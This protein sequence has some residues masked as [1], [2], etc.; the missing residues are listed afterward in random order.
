MNKILL[1]SAAAMLAAFS[2]SAAITDYSK[3]SKLDLSSTEHFNRAKAPM[4]KVN[5]VINDPV[6][7]KG[8]SRFYSVKA[9]TQIPMGQG[10]GQTETDMAKKIIFGDDGFVYFSSMQYGLT[11]EFIK[12]RIEGNK[13][14]V[15]LPQPYV[16]QH[17]LDDNGNEVEVITYYLAP[18]DY[19]IEAERDPDTGQI[20]S[21]Y[22]FEEAEP[23]TLVFAYDAESGSIRQESEIAV[24]TVVEY[25]GE[26]LLFRFADAEY[27]MTWEKNV[28]VPEIPDNL[29]YESYF[30]EYD[31]DFGRPANHYAQVA[32]DGDYIY[33]R[34]ISEFMKDLVLRIEKTAD[35]RWVV[36][37]NQYMGYASGSYVFTYAGLLVDDNEEGY[38]PY[39]EFEFE[40]D[41]EK[42][43]LEGK[44]LGAFLALNNSFNQLFYLELY[45]NPYFTPQGVPDYA[46][47]QG[48]YQMYFDTMFVDMGYLDE[49]GYVVEFYVK[50]I[51]TEGVTLPRDRM[52]FQLFID[53]ELWPLTVD[54]FDVEEDMT[55]VPL[56]LR[57][58]HD[59]NYNAV[60]DYH[61]VSLHFEGFNSVGIA[62]LYENIDGT[63]SASDIATYYRNA[64]DA[65]EKVE[66]DDDAEFF[67]ISG[68]RVQ[69]PGKGLFIK[70]Q[71][72]T[73]TKIVK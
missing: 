31:N 1:F 47:P 67:D 24:G 38:L 54:L 65:V 68:R 2:S 71:N 46:T 34:N 32:F 60:G 66:A 10:I 64:D 33:V 7:P 26:N 15:D 37:V 49:I 45:T 21:F 41:M 8:E 61:D 73:A 52:Y 59:V 70:V 4:M 19:E 55:T 48:V 42:K 72:G 35:G 57:T 13:I 17:N 50:P 44:D 30:F 6:E 22:T 14:L 12:G 43:T 16:Y 58:A 56:D 69:N 9:Y 62:I 40:V 20:V 39:Q 28:I 63:F 5:A 51:S 3:I 25:E 27:D 29:E 11:G 18:L 23:Q 53:G 36:P